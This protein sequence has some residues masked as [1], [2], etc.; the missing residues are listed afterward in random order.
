VG[1]RTHPV[2][3][4]SYVLITVEDS[5]MGIDPKN[6]S[7]IFDPFFTTKSDGMG[8]GLSICRSIKENHGGR[9]SASLGHPMDRS[10]TYFCRLNHL[11]RNKE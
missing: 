1:F 6:V 3:D 4:S 9:L 5:G 2:R 11:L 10:F 8:L 7:R